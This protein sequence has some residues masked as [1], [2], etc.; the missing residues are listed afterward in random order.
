MKCQL[1]CTTHYYSLLLTTTQDYSSITH[2]LVWVKN[3][4]NP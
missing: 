3:F 2:N 1:I 4:N